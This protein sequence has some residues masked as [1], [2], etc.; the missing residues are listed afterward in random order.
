MGKIIEMNKNEAFEEAKTQDGLDTAQ[1]AIKTGER[2][3]IIYEV[4]METIG[5]T[6]EN[7]FKEVMERLKATQDAY[8]EGVTFISTLMKTAPKK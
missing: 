2:T 8:N 5:M 3:R 7:T 1:E 4:L 6:Y